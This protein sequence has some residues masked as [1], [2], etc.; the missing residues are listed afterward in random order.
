MNLER[1]VNNITEYEKKM[2]IRRSEGGVEEMG[3]Q[4]DKCAN[5]KCIK[6]ILN[7]IVN[8]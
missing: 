5:W 8:C 2:N 3:G 1:P 6:Y 4:R 7:D